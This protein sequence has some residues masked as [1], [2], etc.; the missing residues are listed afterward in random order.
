MVG[1]PQQ[2]ERRPFLGSLS[3]YC[4]RSQ[5][6]PGADHIEGVSSHLRNPIWKLSHRQ[7]W[8]LILSMILEPAKLTV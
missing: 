4:L 8:R 1:M 6:V 7:A 5:P 3:L 2:Q